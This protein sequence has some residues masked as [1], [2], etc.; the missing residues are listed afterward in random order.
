MKIKFEK[1]DEL[2][3]GSYISKITGIR[4]YPQK[5]ACAFD[6]TPF[7]NNRKYRNATLWINTSDDDE[8]VYRFFE[9]L[10][11]LNEGE[12]DTDTEFLEAEFLNSYIGIVIK[13][14]EKNG[15]IYHNIVDFYEVDVDDQEEEDD[16]DEE[17]SEELEE[18]DDEEEF[19]ESENDDD[20]EDD[21][22]DFVRPTS[23][24]SGSITIPRREE[25][26]R[27]SNRR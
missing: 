13:D 3:D 11:I 23:R 7:K 19:E 21:F 10:G 5:N 24:R 27:K 9:T 25:K 2:S 20:D 12:V 15:V 1:K 4:P 6:F 26:P 14:N 8:I 18:D 22:E 16:S 17:E